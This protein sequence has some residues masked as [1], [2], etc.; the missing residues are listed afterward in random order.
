MTLQ[1]Y[2]SDNLPEQIGIFWAMPEAI[3]TPAEKKW[4]AG[5]FL[6]YSKNA[7]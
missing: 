5:L 1:Q 2:G 7:A 3:S 4:E 6:Q